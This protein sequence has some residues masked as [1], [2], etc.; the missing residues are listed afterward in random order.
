MLSVYKL[1]T[2]QI[3]VVVFCLNVVVIILQEFKKLFRRW[4]LSVLYPGDVG[5]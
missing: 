1:D 5:F 3:E 2:E 4:A